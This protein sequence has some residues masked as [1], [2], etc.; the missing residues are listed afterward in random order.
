MAV[1]SPVFA[2]ALPARERPGGVTVL[3]ILYFIGAGAMLL[4][5]VFLFVAG[6]AIAQFFGGA[7]GIGDLGPLLAAGAAFIGMAVL[8]VAALVGLV[9]WGQWTGK[10]W[11]WVV[12]LVI[13]GLSALGSLAN[14]AQGDMGSLLGLAIAGLIIW[15]FFTPPVKAW[16]GRG[17]EAPAP[18]P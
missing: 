14:V 4:F 18:P 16:F 6:Q 9:G 17:T 11:A 5:A 15:Y 8:A 3:A 12:T 13:E 1:A 7:D 10:G 2:P